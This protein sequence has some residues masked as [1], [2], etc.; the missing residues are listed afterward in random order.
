MS[1]DIAVVMLELRA[2]QALRLERGLES[3]ALAPAFADVS[4]SSTEPFRRRLIPSLI[5]FVPYPMHNTAE[6]SDDH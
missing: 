4:P 3:G 2:K 6:V 5:V 1:W